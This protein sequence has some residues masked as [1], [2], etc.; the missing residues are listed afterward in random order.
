MV[1]ISSRAPPPLYFVKAQLL[2]KQGLGI[3]SDFLLHR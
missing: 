1:L 2:G 3:D